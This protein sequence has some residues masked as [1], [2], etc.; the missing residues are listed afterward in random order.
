MRVFIGDF[1]R[2]E[3]MED[4]GGVLGLRLLVFVRI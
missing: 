3:G 2:G 4:G 1:V